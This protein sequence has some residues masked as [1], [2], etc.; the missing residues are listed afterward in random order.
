MTRRMALAADGAAVLGPPI[1]PG[2]EPKL[3]SQ[4]PAAGAGRAPGAGL[5]R[6][7]GK[8]FGSPFLEHVDRLCG[9]SAPTT[10]K[11]Q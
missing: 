7:V 1:P 5:L 11:N 6:D 10:A 4:L 8:P 2:R 9:R 3:R